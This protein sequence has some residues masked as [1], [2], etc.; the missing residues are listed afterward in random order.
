M[1]SALG[2]ALSAL[3]A[4]TVALNVSANN[5]ANFNTAGFKSK[6]VILQESRTPGVRAFIEGTTPPFSG[7]KEQLSNVDMAVELAGMIVT[8]HTFEANVLSAR[9]ADEA[10]RSLIDI[11]A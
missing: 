10:E 3:K 5:L 7:S 6:R 8:T 2:T 11:I 1:S 9:V 4:C